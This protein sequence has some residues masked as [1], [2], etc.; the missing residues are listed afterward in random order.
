M[1][2]SSEEWP[3][4]KRLRLPGGE[5]F[6][7]WPWAC[8]RSAGFPADMVLELTDPALGALA[9]RVLA[10]A[11]EAPLP[12]DARR[13]LEDAY[14]QAERRVAALTRATAREPRFREAVIW[15]NPLAVRTGLD[16]LTR[17]P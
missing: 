2:S 6:E 16:I 10:E 5:S 1:R 17:K 9:E 15:Q 13:T 7:V 4:E 11:E 8:V 12:P 3:R 14:T